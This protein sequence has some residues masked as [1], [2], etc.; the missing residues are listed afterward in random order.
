MQSSSTEIALA[1]RRV[2]ETLEVGRSTS[3]RLSGETILIPNNADV[4]CK[5][6]SDAVTKELS[7]RVTWDLS[8]S[9]SR[10]IRQHSDTVVD[11]LGNVYDVFIYGEPRLD[12]NWEG[13]LEFIPV[14]PVLPSRRTERETTQPDLA[15]LEYW[16]TGLEP[17]YLAGAFERAT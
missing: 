15:A 11:T 6:E 13:W 5:Y 10:L 9:T 4:S 12:G 16:A 2:A 3:I 8:S 7:V 1:L 14:S 17:M